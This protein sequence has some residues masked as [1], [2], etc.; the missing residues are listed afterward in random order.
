M[1]LH[2]LGLDHLPT[3]PEI[4]S[5]A[6]TQ[7]IIKL[8]KMCLMKNHEV[9]YYGTEGTN[10][11]VTNP[12]YHFI[13]V[14]KTFE[15]E[16]TYGKYDYKS[17][18][19]RTSP[20]NNQKNI[21]RENFN[22]RT[23]EYINS[24]KQSTDLLLMTMGNWHNQ[25]K[26]AVGLISIESG[27]GYEGIVFDSKGKVF[28][29][30]A[31]MHYLYGKYGIKDGNW[32]DCVIPNYFDLSQFS[33]VEKPK[34]SGPIGQYKDGFENYY[35][36]T[37]RLIYR[38]GLDVAA[39]VARI[40]KKTLIV[41]G[42]GNL[43]SRQQNLNINKK[44]FPNVI[45][46]GAVNADERNRLMGNALVSFAPTYYI[47]PFGG[48]NVESQLCGTP[49][50]TTD[51]GAYPETIQHGKTGYR[52]RTFEQFVWAA[53]AAKDLDRKYIREYAKNNYSM[54]R[55]ADMYDEYF[56]QMQCFNNDGIWYYDRFRNKNIGNDYNIN[57]NG[58]D[59]L[60]WLKR[61]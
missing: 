46:V 13:E 38:K 24:N 44:E 39:Q 45:H 43:V 9:F 5:C 12:L 41:A 60:D 18:F 36:F 48:V 35:L 37:G 16:Q 11:G 32:W 6:Y 40:N 34:N 31:W 47:E 29:S 55:C 2:I 25:I 27:I 8:I 7:K 53:E 14:G 21:S 56:H 50:I 19:F 20:I 59:K 28:E 52:C 10:I 58:R 3:T 61:F 33:F 30:Y 22:K 57:C 15:R 42:Q 51:W 17:S 26:N 1:R 54:E 4:L 23:I 49:V